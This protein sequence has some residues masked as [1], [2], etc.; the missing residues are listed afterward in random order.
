MHITRTVSIMKLYFGDIMTFLN[1]VICNSDFVR[2]Y[3]FLKKVADRI[4]LINSNPYQRWQQLVRPP[5]LLIFS[6]KFK[7]EFCLVSQVLS[8]TIMLH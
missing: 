2:N 8:V 1:S 7:V 5:P 3:R 4:Y 6:P